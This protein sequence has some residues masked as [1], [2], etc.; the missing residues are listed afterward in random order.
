MWN[1]LFFLYLA[2]IKGKLRR[3]RYD[4]AHEIVLI[5]CSLVVLTLFSY[6]FHD[7][8]FDELK[9]LDEAFFAA[10]VGTG[11]V[12]LFLLMSLALGRKTA[13]H[14]YGA[15]PSWHN[16]SVSLGELPSISTAQRIIL[17]VV[18][19]LVGWGCLLAI[20]RFKRIALSPTV[21][22]TT[23]ALSLSV[24][25]GA[26]FYFRKQSTTSP[27]PLI[28]TGRKPIPV[29]TRWRYFTMVKRNRTS[30]LCLG[31]VALLGVMWLILDL[32]SAPP[33][34]LGFLAFLLGLGVTFAVA[35][36]LADDLPACWLEKNAGISHSDFVK[37]Y[38]DLCRGLAIG[39]FCLVLSLGLGSHLQELPKNSTA[40]FLQHAQVALMATVS[41]LIFP[42]LMLQI[43][44]R[45][46]IVQLLTT[47]LLGL[48]LATAVYVNPLAFLLVFLLR[49]F[50]FDAQ[51]E[52]FYRA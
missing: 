3:L 46:P 21:L 1:R 34:V 9:H 12:I 17:L 33:V 25:V 18:E 31:G 26:F 37:T 32:R 23:V 47:M 36:Q 19:H 28:P 6:V 51:K 43:E 39:L 8:L 30:R 15:T 48:F 24:W 14:I 38:D 52:R 29:M 20:V 45:K 2:E 41:P 13:A 7:F 27:R 22:A 5:F 16:F 10:A 42:S 44:G 50:A 49:H 11:T 4:L 40:L 35:F